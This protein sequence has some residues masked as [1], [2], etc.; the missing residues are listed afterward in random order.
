MSSNCLVVAS[1]L[2]ASTGN[3][4]ISCRK[5]A[6]TGRCNS[7]NRSFPEPPRATN[8]VRSVRASRRETATLRLGCEGTLAWDV[9]ARQL[10]RYAFK[11]WVSQQS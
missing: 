10:L 5:N 7:A 4:D 9:T 1:F 2:G 3:L 6:N 11:I 8:D